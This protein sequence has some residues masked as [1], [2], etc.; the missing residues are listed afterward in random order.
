MSLAEMGSRVGSGKDA[1]WMREVRKLTESGH[2][3]SLIGTAFKVA[4][5]DLAA[6]L[7]TRWCQ[8]NFLRYMMQHF[9]LDL[10]TEHKTAPLSDTERVVNPAWRDLDKQKRS[11]QGKLR[12]RQAE[13][14]A[15]TLQAEPGP[16]GKRFQKWTAHKAKLLQE[17]ENLDAEL[18]QVKEALKSTQQHIRWEQLPEEHKFQRLAPTRRRLIDTVRMIAYRA[19][20]AMVPLLRDEHTDAPAARAMLQALFRSSGDIL[21]EPEHNRLRI[22][23][24]RTSTP[25]TDRRIQNLCDQLNAAE[26]PYP[27]TDLTLVY[28]LVAAA[29]PESQN[30]VTLS[31]PK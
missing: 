23:L 18:G 26:M 13:F 2:Q 5:T 16:E 19:E 1:M 25:A 6:S 9:A 11:V 20:T 30:G 8:E 21:P 15:L 24:H 3:V 12:R 29:S 10:L 31:S 17:I 22:R 4:H 27:G 14:A 7:F 28:E